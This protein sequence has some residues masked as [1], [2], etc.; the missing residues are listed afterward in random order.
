[1]TFPFLVVL[2]MHIRYTFAFRYFDIFTMVLLVGFL[3]AIFSITVSKGIYNRLA[4]IMHLDN[5]LSDFSSALPNFN[6]DNID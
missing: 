1:M 3:L 5:Y 2:T 4:L 6:Y